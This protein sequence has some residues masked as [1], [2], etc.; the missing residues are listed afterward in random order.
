MEFPCQKCNRV[1]KTNDKLDGHMNQAHSSPDQKS[2][3]PKCAK[4][5]KRKENLRDHTRTVHADKSQETPCDECGKVFN[6]RKAMS[7]HKRLFHATETNLCYMC[8][9]KTKDTAN[10]AK[11]IMRIHLKNVPKY[12]CTLC[13]ITTAN[14]GNLDVHM[15]AVHYKV[16]MLQC[17]E[18]GVNV[19]RHYELSRHC[20]M[21]HL[22]VK[23]LN[24][25]ISKKRAEKMAVQNDRKIFSCP[26]CDKRVWLNSE[27]IEH[28][29]KVHL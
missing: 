13:P 27:I 14:K 28:I 12:Q 17:Y 15:N 5:F 23:S 2:K 10:L 16:K 9:F 11:H 29:E 24:D 21:V 19:A 4:E 1:F 20:R 6:T 18:C 8:G 26:Y 25:N 3:C 7:K 22:K